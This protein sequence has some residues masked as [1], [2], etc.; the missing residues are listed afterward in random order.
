MT[1]AA[2]AGAS[3]WKIMET[4]GHRTMDTVR[5]YVRN[6]ELFQDHALAGVL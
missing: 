6:A 2:E 4:S 5:Q 1:S 3:I